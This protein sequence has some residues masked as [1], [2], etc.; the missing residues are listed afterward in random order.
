MASAPDDGE[1]SIVRSGFRR[2]NKNARRFVPGFLPRLQH[3]DPLYTADVPNP[4]RHCETGG[5]RDLRDSVGLTLANFQNR[6]PARPE[7]SRKV[8]EQVTHQLKTVKTAVESSRRVM[9]DLNR[10]PFDVIRRHIGE[11]CNNQV[12]WRSGR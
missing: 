11:V 1:N 12:P 3:N 4:S 6:S 8:G 10:Y 7:K 2:V 5:R 9:T